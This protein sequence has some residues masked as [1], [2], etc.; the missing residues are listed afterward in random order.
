MGGSAVAYPRAVIAEHFFRLVALAAAAGVGW[1]FNAITDHE[2]R[3]AQ[4]ESSRFTAKEG[5]ALVQSL[6]TKFQVVLDRLAAT[7]AGV[8]DRLART[9]TKVDAMRQDIQRLLER[10]E[11]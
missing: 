4:I 2:V 8:A 9:E 5:R 6:E 11:R 10:L 7:D 3:L 1:G